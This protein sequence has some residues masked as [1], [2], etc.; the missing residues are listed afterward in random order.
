MTDFL[1]QLELADPRSQETKW[2]E[3]MARA[4]LEQPRYKGTKVC[5]SQMMP[6]QLHGRLFKQADRHGLTLTDMNN[7]ILEES[8]KI[9][10]HSEPMKGRVVQHVDRRTR[11]KRKNPAGRVA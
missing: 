10:E 6:A 11:A 1:Q 5:W 7:F 8:L 2:V 9:L 3:R 4:I